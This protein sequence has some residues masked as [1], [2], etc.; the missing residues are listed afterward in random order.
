MNYRPQTIYWMT[1]AAWIGGLLMHA[2]LY[3]C[4]VLSLPRTEEAYAFSVPF[5]LTAFAYSRGGFWLVGLLLALLLEFAVLG[6][7]K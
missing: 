4:D 2:I 5:Q 7:R 1:L 3:V 6:R